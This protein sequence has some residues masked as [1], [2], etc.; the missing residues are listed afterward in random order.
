VVILVFAI[1][2]VVCISIFVESY[3]MSNRTIET[4][5]AIR[6]ASNGAEGFKAAGGDIY[7]TLRLLGGFNDQTDYGGVLVVYYNDKWATSLKE[8]ALY[9]LRINKL[10][11]EVPG[12]IVAGVTVSRM[13]GDKLYELTIAA[14]GK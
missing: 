10:D 2:S 3:L 12:L 4:N 7:E 13:D 5:N 14:R 8:D 6:T 1:C 9:V 11:E